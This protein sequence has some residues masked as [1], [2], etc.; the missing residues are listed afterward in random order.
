M[1]YKSLCRIS[2]ISQK[3]HHEEEKPSILFMHNLSNLK[4]ALFMLN[5]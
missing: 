4:W 5:I 3:M 1:H 2:R